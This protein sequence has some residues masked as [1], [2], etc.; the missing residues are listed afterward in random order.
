MF[1]L[2]RIRVQ[3]ACIYIAALLA[4]AQERAGLPQ[5]RKVDYTPT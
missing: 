1:S 2:K 3:R 5:A 4:S